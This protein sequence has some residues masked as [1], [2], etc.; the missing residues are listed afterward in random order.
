MC[1]VLFYF[2]LQCVILG[3]VKPLT[4]HRREAADLFSIPRICTA[5]LR[6]H[7]SQSRSPRV[8]SDPQRQRE[9]AGTRGEVAV[10][11]GGAARARLAKAELATAHRLDAQG[12]SCMPGPMYR[13]LGVSYSGISSSV[14][15]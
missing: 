10:S 2:C 13:L 14:G 6:C 12:L 8:G 4:M 9:V 3:E 5:R 15:W 1:S 7:R 11:P